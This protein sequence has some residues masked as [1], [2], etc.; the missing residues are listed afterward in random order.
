MW[1]K[2]QLFDEA[3][4][5]A[6]GGGGGNPNPGGDP[7]PGAGDQTIA[8]LKL[9]DL[10][11]MLQDGITGALN[12]YDK[13][14]QTTLKTFTPPAA[15]DPNKKDP[16][17]DPAKKKDGDGKDPFASAREQEL[18]TRLETIE[19]ERLA[20]KTSAQKVQ[21]EAEVKSALSEFTWSEGGKDIAL[22][23]YL[24]QATRNDAGE[25]V[26]GEMPLARYIKEHL[27]R[28]PLKNLLAAR[29]V[30]GAGADKGGAG[31]AGSI[32]IEDIKPG[33]SK[34]SMA[35]AGAALARLKTSLG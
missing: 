29:Q 27:P 5:A 7:N 14:I 30:G 1:P 33:M 2:S 13:K 4:P 24:S 16:P 6:G 3:D 20:E 32:Q 28:S 17:A 26:I 35:A 11:K 9:S 22:Q 12:T 21:L 18:T 15:A 34:E 23:H 25:L 8:N 10:T 31:G 19:K